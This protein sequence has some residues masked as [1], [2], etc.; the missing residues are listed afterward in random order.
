MRT[1]HLTLLLALVPLSW[2]ADAP[3]SSQTMP[4]GELK[5]DWSCFEQ[6]EEE[7]AMNLG[8]LQGVGS[9]AG[10]GGVAYG[11]AG[12]GPLPQRSQSHAACSS[13]GCVLGRLANSGTWGYG[14]APYWARI[15][16]DF[17]ACLVAIRSLPIGISVAGV[18]QRRYCGWSSRSPSYISARRH[19]ARTHRIGSTQPYGW[20]ASRAYSALACSR[21]PSRSNAS[22]AK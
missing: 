2:G 4:R 22:A 17:A 9:G 14:H 8:G 3:A 13:H 18:E 7:E 6:I 19:W 21:S 1:R 11:R 5:V 20:A 10:G 15:A 12:A 16:V